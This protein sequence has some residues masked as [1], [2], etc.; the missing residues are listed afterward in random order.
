MQFKLTSQQ[1]VIEWPNIHEAILN[2]R[3]NLKK[4]A[5]RYEK[6][7]FYS[8]LNFILLLF[9]LLFRVCQLFSGESWEGCFNA[10]S[11]HCGFLRIFQLTREHI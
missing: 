3:K 5:S 11:S 2:K 8:Y 7:I 10:I 9:Y 6:V 1:L 4:S